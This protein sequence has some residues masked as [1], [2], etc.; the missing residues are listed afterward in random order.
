[1]RVQAERPKP[2]GLRPAAWP[3]VDGLRMVGGPDALNRVSVAPSGRL[4]K[5]HRSGLLPGHDPCAVMLRVGRRYT[6]RNVTIWK[7]YTKNVDGCF[8]VCTNHRPTRRIDWRKHTGLRPTDV[9]PDESED[10][11][12]VG[13]FGRRCAWAL[14]G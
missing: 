11:W 2:S 3:D 12:A 1:P 9:R 13:R 5:H 8:F 10:D 14:S 7:D 6:G 4:S